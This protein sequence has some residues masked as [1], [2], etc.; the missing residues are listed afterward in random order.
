[1]QDQ[2]LSW[3]KTLQTE[4]HTAAHTAATN[5]PMKT[6]A[7]AKDMAEGKRILKTAIQEKNAAVISESTKT[8]IQ[9]RAEQLACA[10]HQYQEQVTKPDQKFLARL[11][12][13]YKKDC[14]N[15]IA[16]L[17]ALES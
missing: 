2:E 3:A 13:Q 17:P 8:L 1:M 15:L 11:I 16:A 6:I 4:K 14:E 10:I 7:I 12:I 5:W 9:L